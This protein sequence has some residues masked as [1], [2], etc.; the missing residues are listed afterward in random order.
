MGTYSTMFPARTKSL[1]VPKGTYSD[2]LPHKHL[3]HYIVLWAP[4]PSHCSTGPPTT[5][6]YATPLSP[7][8]LYGGTRTCYCMHRNL[9]ARTGV[10]GTLP[11][12][13]ATPDCPGIN[14]ISI[15][16][17]SH[18][19]TTNHAK[20]L[21]PGQTIGQKGADSHHGTTNVPSALQHWACLDTLGISPIGGQ[22]NYSHQPS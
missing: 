21:P 2:T 17:S 6:A 14:N 5:M 18:H 12:N 3:F 16:G 8:L 9:S 4:T 1:K 13:R 19:P 15:C 7:A 20:F 11:P 10:L 22:A